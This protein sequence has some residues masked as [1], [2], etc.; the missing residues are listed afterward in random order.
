M[1]VGARGSGLCR[2][3]VRERVTA[4]RVPLSLWPPH[5]PNPDPTPPQHPPRPRHR[6]RPTA[7]S[8][9]RDVLPVPEADAG[10]DEPGA[11]VRGGLPEIVRA[12]V[13]PAGVCGVLRV[14]GAGAEAGGGAVGDAGGGG[15]ETVTESEL[16]RARVAELMRLVMSLTE[17]LAVVSE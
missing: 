1:R 15:I 14:R 10:L 4:S 17:K 3:G 2:N 11:G 6:G 16:L 8:Q 9:A 5:A 13:R 7:G 12:G